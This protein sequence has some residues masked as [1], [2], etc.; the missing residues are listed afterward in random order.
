MNNRATYSFIKEQQRRV[1]QDKSSDSETLFLATRN[2]HP[3]LSNHGL[4]AVGE[5]INAVMDMSSSRC[6]EDLF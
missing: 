4:V 2:H 3:A 6:F 5:L 1:F